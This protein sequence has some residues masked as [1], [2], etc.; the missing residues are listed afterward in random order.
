L[1]EVAGKIT[2][3]SPDY[4]NYGRIVKLEVATLADGLDM[5]ASD[6]PPNRDSMAI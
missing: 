2:E 3:G 5:K 4:R 1:L 6:D